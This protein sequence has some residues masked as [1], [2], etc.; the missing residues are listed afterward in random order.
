VV[1]L[2]ITDASDTVYLHPNVVGAC[3]G[4]SFLGLANQLGPLLFCSCRQQ[5][6][7]DAA[8]ESIPLQKYGPEPAEAAQKV[9]RRLS[10][11]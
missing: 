4:G 5:Q 9:P 7:A 10:P 11:I 6:V 2:V 1:D 8:G 3:A